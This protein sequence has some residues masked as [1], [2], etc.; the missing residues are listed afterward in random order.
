[1]GEDVSEA[2]VRLDPD[3]TATIYSDLAEHGT[4]QRSSICKLVAEILQIPL[5]RVSVTSTDSQI[6][7]FEFG[8][9]GSRGTYAIG[10]AVIAAAEDAKRQLLERMARKF[11]VPPKTWQRKTGWSMCK[12]IPGQ[13]SPGSP[14]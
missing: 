1:M 8:P 3:G 5:D 4:G 7:P 10:S 12:G 6:N 13:S 11:N 14:G 9:V 2:F